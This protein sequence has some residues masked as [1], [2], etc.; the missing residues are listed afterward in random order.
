M[1]KKEITP[2][3]LGLDLGAYSM[4]IAFHLATGGVSHAIGREP[5]GA[6]MYSKIIVPH[7]VRDIFDPTRAVSVIK[8]FAE[9]HESVLL[10]PCE[11]WYVRLVSAIGHLLPENV[12]FHLPDARLLDMV[13]DKSKFY[14]LLDGFGIDYP[15]TAV[16]YSADQVTDR[17]LSLFD[18]PA[19]VKPSDSSEYWRFPFEG[20]KKVYFPQSRT[21]AAEIIKRIFASGYGA[22]VILQQKMSAADEHVG[23]YTVITDKCA[24]CV[25]GVFGDVMLGE[26]TP[27]GTGNHVA[28]ITRKKPEICKKLDRFLERIGY[29]GI[30]NFDLIFNGDKW[31]VLEL[32]PRQG[33]SSDYMRGAG[34]NIASVLVDVIYGGEV[35]GFEYGESFWRAVSKKTLYSYCPHVHMLAEA[36]ILSSL[37]AESYLYGYRA[38]TVRNPIRCAYSLYHAYRHNR[39]F[40]KYGAV[41]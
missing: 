29:T 30:A 14:D 32:N 37:G 10:V 7:V 35:S 27:S 28:I 2:L 33:R 11:D 3:L 24:R 6:T 40:A 26:P 16:F 39:R 4:A 18:Y 34:V 41:N 12:K 31:Y 38:D 13:S 8:E 5:L 15:K 23:V 17:L 19:V 9:K 25:G 21:E 36:Q 20:M 22:S 1:D